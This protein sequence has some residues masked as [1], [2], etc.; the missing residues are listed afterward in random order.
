M[1]TPNIAIIG[2][3]VAGLTF[4]RVLQVH[5]I[6]STVFELDTFV[7]SRN[8]GGTL[9]LHLESGQAALHAAGLFS[10]FQSHL[11]SD[12]QERRTLDK[13]GAIL[14]HVKSEDNIIERPEID[15]GD[16]RQ[17][18]VDSIEKG[19]IQ[20]GTRVHE[21]KP[22]QENVN[23]YTV[24]YNEG[25]E[26]TFDMVVGAD[27]AWSKVRALLSSAKP[28][29]SS[30]SFIE[31]RITDA[32]ARFPEILETTGRGGC[33]IVSDGKMLG[34]G[35]IADKSMLIYAGIPI[36]EDQLSETNT[37]FSKPAEGRRYLLDKYADWDDRLK[38]LIRLCDDAI[39]PRPIYALPVPHI[40]ESKPGLTLIGDA[41]HLM[42]PFAGAGANMAMWDGKELALAISDAVKTGTPLVEAVTDFE[43]RMYEMTRPMAELSASNLK[44]LTSKATAPQLVQALT[45]HPAQEESA[46]EKQPC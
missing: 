16:L 3:G 26:A 22:S 29:Y 19:V 24:V 15:R 32:E 31:L 28:M 8:Q 25:H 44:L 30:L 21:I 43:R 12:A 13:H 23:K 20:W 17:I 4:A 35:C 14:V 7:R 41:A 42:S 1:S 9:D 18:L 34:A 38:D 45:K 36:D 10:K 2:A 6:H 39:I 33:F 11:R 37:I 46:R 40:W 27:G 5:G